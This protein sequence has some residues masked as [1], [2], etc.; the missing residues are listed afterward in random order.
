MKF[1][2]TPIAALVASLLL[3][4]ASSIHILPDSNGALSLQDSYDYIVVGAG[5]GG[6]VVANR[7]S[8]DPTISVLVIEARDLDDRA[9]DV[10]IPGNIGLEDPRRYKVKLD[11]AV[12]EFLD[13]KERVISQGKVVG[14]STIVNGLV[15]TRG[16]MA[17]FDAWERLGNPGWGWA[18][19]LPYFKKCEKYTVQPS[20]RPAHNF[21]MDVYP[22]I[23]AHG[24]KG[25]VEVGYPN[26]YYNQS[27][28]FLDG[29]QE[30]GIP[31]NEDPNSG[32]ATGASL[33][34]SSMVAKNQSRSDARIAYLDPVLNRPNLHLVTGH[35]VT[36]ILYD[37]DGATFLN[38]TYIPGASGLNMIG[39][40][41]AANSTANKIRINCEVEVILA[42]G[43]I[44]SPVLLQISGIGPAKLLGNLGVDIA[45]DLP[46]VGSNLQD[47]PTLQPVYKYTS[48]DVFSAWDIVGSTRDAVREEYFTNRT[49]PWTAP[50]VDIIALPALSWVT[51]DLQEWLDEAM[52][53]TNNLPLFYDETLHA[54]YLAQRDEVISMLARTDTPAYEVMSTSWGQLGVSAMQPLSRGTVL[55]KSSS[56]FENQP[57]I[58]PRFCSHSIDCKLLLLALGFNDQLIQT[59]PMAA[60]IPVAPPGFG[61]ADARNQT[62]VDEA[63]RSIIT[64]GFHLSGTT[65]MLPIDLGG[66]VDSSLTVYGTRNLRV[67]DAGII[68]LL[69]AA[70]IQAALYAIAEKAADIIKAGN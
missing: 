37:N 6:L 44:F 60:L 13:G 16:S 57:I 23:E 49:G 2:A 5:I 52:N 42:A 50:M 30:L 61:I 25:P 48:P 53:T 51:D 22:V 39:V 68:P 70:H 12:Q 40:E 34:P 35:T 67:V 33:I 32:N 64:S 56:M 7:L 10:S 11:L 59:S 65:S 9:E 3:P 43:A 45:I 29:I 28:N 14:G 38:S 4:L 47:H 17:N 55:A 1:G 69:P 54:G 63:M 21:P 41:F 27:C 20:N 62:M 66:V 8:E 36:C 31:V 26:Y 19:L 58:D 46:G 15:W 24:N 18:G